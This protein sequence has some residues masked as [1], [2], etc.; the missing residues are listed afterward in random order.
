MA[1]LT[2]KQKIEV[3]EKY[4]TGDYTCQKLGNE[5][6]ITKV[7]IRDILIR[8]GIKLK[9][10]SES[11]RKYTLNENYFDIIDTEDKAYFL[12][13][14]YAD[15]CNCTNNNCIE[16]SLQ[17]ED[18]SILDTFNITIGSNKPLYFKQIKVKNPKRKNQYKLEIVSK[19]MSQKLLELGCIPKK[20]LTLKFPDEN[21][22]PHYLL[23]HFIRGYFDGDG[24][25]GI[26]N[27]RIYFNIV[28]TIHFCIHLKDVIEK[29]LNII[30]KINNV[31]SNTIT[32]RLVITGNMNIKNFL[33]WLYKDATVYL[34]RKYNLFL[35]S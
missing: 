15:G 10:N 33:D 12:G 35:L 24:H 21:Q 11:H 8:R 20:S 22:V 17:E 13:L 26:Y 1:K 30:C 19:Y 28:S 34:D 4:L 18:K 25:I 6:N 2:D 23:Q 9:S 27:K 14:L 32:K 7:S 29:Q 5:Y 16:I 3:V 31:K